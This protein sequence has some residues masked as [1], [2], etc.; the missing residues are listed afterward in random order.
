LSA[1]IDL[2]EFSIG[3]AGQ[4]IFP[5]YN[6]YLAYEIDVRYTGTGSVA[7]NNSAEL[8]TSLFRQNAQN[9]A[10]SRSSLVTAASPDL[11][12]KS[13][14]IQTY[15][16]NTSDPFIDGGVQ[17]RA[18]CGTAATVSQIDIIIKGVKH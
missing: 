9:V 2:S 5:A 6:G 17:I 18:Q 13:T 11:S 7:G 1:N 12:Q 16:L 8:V 14:S 3:S 15:T 10:V 4:L